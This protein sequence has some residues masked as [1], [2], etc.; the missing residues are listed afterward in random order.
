MVSNKPPIRPEMR[1][2][3]KRLRGVFHEGT[4]VE[5]V[6][7][8]DKYAPPVGTKGTVVCVDDIGTI[9]VKWDNG[10]T[11]GVVYGVDKCSKIGDP[12]C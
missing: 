1:K 6:E 9:I 12:E 5:L 2:I 4:R 7:M 3:L 8:D 10:S 11:L